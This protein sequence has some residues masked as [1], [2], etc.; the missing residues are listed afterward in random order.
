MLSGIN[1]SSPAFGGARR[2]A[3][4]LLLMPGGVQQQP[5]H[6]RIPHARGAMPVHEREPAYTRVERGVPRISII[7]IIME[8][9]VCLFPANRR[10]PRKAGRHN[11][12]NEESTDTHHDHMLRN[13][14]PNS[15]GDRF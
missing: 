5:A 7:T 3:P 13:A 12:H 2:S 1:S 8:F 10:A 15:P 14:V 4:Q 11:K 9:I 6:A